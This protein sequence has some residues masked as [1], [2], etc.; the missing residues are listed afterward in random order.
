MAKFSELQMMQPKRTPVAGVY[1]RE[2]SMKALDD[3]DG[4]SSCFLRH[5][6]DESGNPLPCAKSLRAL[7]RKVGTEGLAE[8]QGFLERESG[9]PWDSTAAE[10][11]ASFRNLGAEV[12]ESL[13]NTIESFMERIRTMP[14][15][16]LHGLPA[17]FD[18]NHLTFG[19]PEQERPIIQ[20][21]A[22]LH[23]EAAEF[24]REIKKA[25][26]VL[27]EIEDRLARIDKRVEEAADQSKRNSKVLVWTLGV[28]FTSLV[29]AAPQDL[30]WG[31][32]GWV[33]QVFW[34]LWQM[35]SW[36]P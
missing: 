12:H 19:P 9:L 14:L 13:R 21:V 22:K 30:P 16:G 3:M 7:N 35:A 1:W 36:I 18:R 5:W 10:V 2:F 32:V 11:R 6:V 4:D 24:H 17:S 8:L 25:P 15:P 33:T 26:P 28:A 23:R 29:I 20:H 31:W 27:A 34:D